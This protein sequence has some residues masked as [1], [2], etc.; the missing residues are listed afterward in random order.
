MED[1]PQ[2]VG[3]ST[4]T[5]SAALMS[6]SMRSSASVRLPERPRPPYVLLTPWNEILTWLSWLAPGLAWAERRTCRVP[7]MARA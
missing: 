5:I 3:P 4:V 1:L 6:T 2:P 7:C